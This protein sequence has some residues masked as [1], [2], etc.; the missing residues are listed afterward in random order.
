[1]SDFYSYWTFGSDISASIWNG[2]CALH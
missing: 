1:M 2:V